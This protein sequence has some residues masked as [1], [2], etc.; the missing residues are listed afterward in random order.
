[1]STYIIFPTR[2][3]RLIIRRKKSD[4]Y[5]CGKFRDIY[6]HILTVHRSRK[7]LATGPDLCQ[8]IISRIPE[9][10]SKH[11]EAR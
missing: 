2:V 11:K 8:N 7:L 9:L 10:S 1:M 6:A 5:T 3:V 4:L